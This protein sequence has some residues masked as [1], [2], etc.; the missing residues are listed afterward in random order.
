MKRI[1]TCWIAL[2]IV[3]VAT[4]K[5]RADE[6]TDWNQILLR[7]GLL[8][9]TTPLGMTRNA[10]LVQSA[11]FDAV[12]GIDRRYTPIHVDPAGPK[13]AS[14]RAAAVQAAYVMLSKL[15]PTQ[16]G[17][18]DTRRKIAMAVIAFHEKD[19]IAAGTTWGDK[20]ATDI[21][22][23]RL[24]DGFAVTTPT[25]PGNTAPGQWRP[26]PNAPGTGTSPNGAGYPQFFNMTTWSLSPPS[27]APAP[28]ALT[29][30]RYARDFDEVKKMGSFSSTAR[31]PDQTIFS[32]FWNSATVSYLWNTVALSLIDG[33]ER[34]DDGQKD[35][36][37]GHH[38]SNTLLENARVLGELNVAMA[39]AA[40][41]C[42]STKYTYN[43]W[44]PITAIRETSDP[45]WTPLFTTP[46]HPS[47]T[48]G[49][50]CNSAAAAA[51]LADEFGEKTHFTVN[52]DL[53]LGVTRSFRSFS[54][55][56]EEV[57]NARIFAGIHFRFDCEEGQKLGEAVA[58]YV[59]ESKFQR[60][61]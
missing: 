23:W 42:Y 13:G 49:H 19:D 20:V 43:V 37:R 25:W 56:L 2:L 59:L 54:A 47:Y 24:A 10:A 53:M 26:T 6:V 48:S 8:A 29:D 5:A 27:L 15:Y 30:G 4:T 3:L 31:T 1:S 61:H 44:R 22:T 28:P 52:S 46:A 14:R 32:L 7:V 17:I 9:G 50:S 34:D 12:N 55:A 45:A 40:I 60:V 33:D 38:N 51:V 36:K 11:V 58:A 41:G 21:W 39:D 16:Q 57:G 35:W 18:L